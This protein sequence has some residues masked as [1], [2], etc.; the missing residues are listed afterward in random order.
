MSSEVKV[1]MKKCTK[2][3]RQW[4]WFFTLWGAGF[5]TILLISMVIKFAMGSR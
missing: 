1:A 3:A 4:I 2:R 5:M